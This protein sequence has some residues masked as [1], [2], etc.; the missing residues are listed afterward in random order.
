M[1]V[2]RL[3]PGAIDGKVRAPPSKSY[4]HRALVVGFLSGSRYRLVNPLRSADTL[5]TARGLGALGARVRAGRREW[6]LHPSSGTPRP[7]PEIACGESG[8]TL[9]FLAAVA[10]RNA[11]V[12]RFQGDARLA[13]RP[14]DELL[15]ALERRGVNV[16]HP[17]ARSLPLEV[18]G[19]VRPGP[20]R[21]DGSRSSQFVSALLLLLPSLDGDSTLRWVGAAVSRPY[22]AAT[23][24][25]E[26]AHGLRLR[27][28]GRRWSIPGRQHVTRSR[29]EVPGDA[30][31]AAYLWAAAAVTGGRVAVEGISRRWPQADLAIVDLL[32]R[33]GSIAR[34]IPR[35]IEISGVARR[36]VVAD[37]SDSP[38]LFPLV[39][40]VAATVPARSVLRGAPQLVFKETD[41]LRSTRRLLSLLGARV[42]SIPD[43]IEVVG[44]RPTRRLSRVR[45]GD[46]RLVMAGAIAALAADAASTFA[47]VPVVAKSFPG[48]WTALRAIGGEVSGR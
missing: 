6:T 27:G 21:V 3:V 42:R 37:L 5:A 30:S 34:E 29:F 32:E 45:F 22:V 28:T 13:R 19:P 4:T 18:R 20:F 24:A 33:M 11:R 40:A 41:R 9:R 47:D 17:P 36:G 43:G 26:R 38:D 14:I 31:S 25:L 23:V 2:V 39:G 8:T 15:E 46:H 12:V 48:F 16:R 44:R 7:R 35:G 10:A 1:T